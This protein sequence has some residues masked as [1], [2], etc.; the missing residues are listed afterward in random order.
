MKVASI[1]VQNSAAYK[2]NQDTMISCT[3]VPSGTAFLNPVHLLGVFDGQ[4]DC[5][6]AYLL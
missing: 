3:P 1:S 4:F 5:P 6:F 2:P